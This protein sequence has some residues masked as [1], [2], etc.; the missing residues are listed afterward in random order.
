MMFLNH[1][2]S[3]IDVLNANT[4]ATAHLYRPQTNT[5]ASAI[6]QSYDTSSMHLQ[7]NTN[8]LAFA[9]QQKSTLN[10]YTLP[11]SASPQLGISYSTSRHEI[12]PSSSNTYTYPT[13]DSQQTTT[14]TTN[15]A[16]SNL[17]PLN[18]T[19]FNPSLP[20]NYTPSIQNPLIATQQ[21]PHMTTIPN[22]TN[23]NTYAQKC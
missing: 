18:I 6:Q 14:T 12:T 7:S 8:T 17:I 19:I 11:T 23:Y 20:C 21:F 2:F 10:G 3:D 5:T 22:Y 13:A 16:I 15:Q 1:S 4:N 9:C